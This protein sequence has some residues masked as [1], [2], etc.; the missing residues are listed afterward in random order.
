M[1]RR[2]WQTTAHGVMWS[3][4]SKQLTHIYPATLLKSLITSSR[5]FLV[6]SMRFGSF[7]DSSVSNESARNSGDHGSIPGS[8]RSTGEGIGYILQHSWAS[9]VAQLVKIHLQCGRPH[10]DLWVGRIPWSRERLPTP[11]F[12]PE[13]VH[14]LL[15]YTV[16]TVYSLTVH[17]VAKIWTWLRDFHFMRF[18]YIESVLS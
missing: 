5:F 1:D 7:P 4:T 14:G 9:L 13:E 8:G 3:D 17:G 12:W 10:F 18:L 11:V 15:D 16:Y 6:D 2:A